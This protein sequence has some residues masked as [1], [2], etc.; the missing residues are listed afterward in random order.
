MV[1]GAYPEHDKML[2]LTERRDEVQ[3]FL[4]WL[5]DEQHV[6]LA[7]YGEQN[8]WGDRWNESKLT[9]ARGSDPR[10]QTTKFARGLRETIMARY[11]G[12]DLDVITAEKEAMYEEMRRRTEAA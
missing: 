12:I 2:G 9:P 1:D 3:H 6:V 11:L 5:L 7:F 4:D 8:K 10:L